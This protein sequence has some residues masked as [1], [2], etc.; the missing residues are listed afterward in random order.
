MT[1]QKIASV[2]QEIVNI[3]AAEVSTEGVGVS[4]FGRAVVGAWVFVAVAGLVG[5]EVSLVGL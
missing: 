1:E 3:E 4:V 5:V 2:L